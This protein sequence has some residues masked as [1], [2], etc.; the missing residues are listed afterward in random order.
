M[1]HILGTW[2]V[3]NGKL[4]WRVTKGKGEK[5]STQLT[6]SYN[7]LIKGSRT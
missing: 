6:Q 1:E 4:N 7:Q 5:L 2:Q 3:G